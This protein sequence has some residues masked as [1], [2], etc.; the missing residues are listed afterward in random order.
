MERCGF[1][2][3]A[4][5]SYISKRMATAAVGIKRIVV[6]PDSLAAKKVWP[7]G[8]ECTYLTTCF[9]I[10]YKSDQNLKKRHYF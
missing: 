3:Y 5:R 7:T 8:F 9:L 10:V 4:L 2:D 1:R 6:I